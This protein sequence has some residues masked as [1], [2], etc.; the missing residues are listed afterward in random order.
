MA[1]SNVLIC[2][3]LWTVAV[4]EMGNGCPELCVCSDQNKRHFAQCTYQDLTE[5]PGNL[6]PNVTTLNLSNNRIGFITSGCLDRVTAVTSLWMAHNKMVSIEEGSLAPLIHLRNLDVSDNRLVD[7]PWGDL[8][9][10]T[11]LQ[12]LK[13][14]HNEMV[15]LAQDAF[16]NLRDLKSLRLNH[17][18]FTTVARGTFDGLIFISHLQIYNNP[19]TCN[20]SIDW[21]RDWI[22]TTAVSVPEQNLI[23]C[24]NPQKFEGVA[25]VKLPQS[26]CMGPKVTI[27]AELNIDNTDIYEDTSLILTC[28]FR[29]TPK[30]S[31]MWQIRS[32]SQRETIA[33]TSGGDDSAESREDSSFAHKPFIVFSNGTLIIFHVR[34]KDSGNYSCTATNEFGTAE[35]VVAVE[36]VT[37][38][39]PTDT[40]KG[41]QAYISTKIDPTLRQQVTVTSILD[42]S[43]LADAEGQDAPGD[44]PS[45]PSAPPPPPPADTPSTAEHDQRT[46]RNST[47]ASK[48][49]LTS[50][51]KFVSNHGFNGSLEDVKRYT[52]NFGVIAL[53][54]SDTEVMVRLNPLL[55]PDD[56]QADAASAAAAVPGGV[57]HP[58]GLSLCLSSDL[59]GSATQWSAVRPGVD[60]Y[61]FRGLRP[62]TNYSLCLTFTGLDCD[63]QV[64]FAT[65][66][67]APNLLV[68]I[69]VCIGLLTVSTVPLLAAT[70][71][72][73]VYKYRGET[74][75]LVLK[76]RDRYQAERNLGGHFHLQGPYPSCPS[77]S[78]RNIS[79]GGEPEEEEG[80][81]GEEGRG[82]TEDEQEGS[83]TTESFTVSRATTEDCEAGSEY[84]D[85]LP[86]GAEAINITSNYT[87]PSH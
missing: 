16:T 15:A 80:E 11:A 70:C 58:E 21:L 59:E 82:E 12:M 19:F 5:I 41:I 18:Q 22:M 40:K 81:E 68:I 29:G 71:Y 7:F 57:V 64:L 10:L 67:P 27:T 4:I 63:V 54:I 76:A 55:V 49:G 65:R 87:Y 51:T 84:S 31:V 72:H 14:D 38:P 9:N 77:E 30:P 46:Q 45:L 83:Q 78:R 60:T 8:R 26:K 1:A 20:C 79:L 25:L 48:C 32:K 23:V 2:F 43:R 52:F 53:S 62:A 69:S 42:P 35:D 28:D 6:P 39:R 47:H 37:L 74:Y 13:M 50:N 86:L 73:L 36:V 24:A 3:A 61:V 34:R 75:K 17:N 33:V 44:T 56:N 66:R 85:R